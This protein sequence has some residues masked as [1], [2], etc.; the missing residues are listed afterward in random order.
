[1]MSSCFGDRTK[2]YV[3]RC[4]EHFRK[5]HDKWDRARRYRFLPA[6]KDLLMYSQ[7]EPVLNDN[8]NWELYGKAGNGEYFLVAVGSDGNECH[9]KTFHPCSDPKKKKSMRF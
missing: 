1:V 3:D 7:E 8:G 9:V 4:I 2:I 5:D 6:V